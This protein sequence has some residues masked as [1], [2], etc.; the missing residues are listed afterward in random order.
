MTFSE[1]LLRQFETFNVLL[2]LIIV[3]FNYITT[4]ASLNK[5]M[6][7]QKLYEELQEIKDDINQKEN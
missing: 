4:T 1:W 5:Q 3:I 7:E 6:K 2:F